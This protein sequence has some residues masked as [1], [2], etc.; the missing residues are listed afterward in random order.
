[1]RTFGPRFHRQMQANVFRRPSSRLAVP[2]EGRDLE[3][4]VDVDHAPPSPAVVTISITAVVPSLGDIPVDQSSV[5]FRLGVVGP[6][7]GDHLAADDQSD[8][9]WTGYL[10]AA[11]EKIDVLRSLEKEGGQF[12]FS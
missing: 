11:D 5:R 1:M 12:S 4:L 8:A 3:D 10:P 6:L 2:N 9:V 7:D